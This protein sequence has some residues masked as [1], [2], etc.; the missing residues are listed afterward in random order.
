M[1]PVI[2]FL[3]FWILVPAIYLAILAFDVLLII[4]SR[5][6]Q[7]IWRNIGGVV[8]G[9]LITVIVI[10]LNQTFGTILTEKIGNTYETAW[11]SAVIFGIIGFIV[12]LAI[13]FL[14]RRGIASFVIMFTVLGVLLS[15]YFLLTL[16]EIRTTTALATIGFLIGVILYFIIFPTRIFNAIS[17]KE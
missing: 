14:L 7:Q 17:G 6:L 12:L 4:K 5:S 2:Q 9:I 15:G 8:I 16:S 3:V 11:T 13:D 1:D 10:M